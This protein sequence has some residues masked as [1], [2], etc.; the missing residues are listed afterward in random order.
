MLLNCELEV[1]LLFCQQT[2][3]FR[4]PLNN[5]LF[6]NQHQIYWLNWKVFLNYNLCHS[7]RIK[8]VFLKNII[9]VFFLHIFSSIH[10][11]RITYTLHH[12]R[13]D[14]HEVKY[15]RVPTSVWHNRLKLSILTFVRWKYNNLF[16]G[17]ICFYCLL[18]KF[19][20]QMFVFIILTLLKLFK[21]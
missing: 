15:A 20:F 2:Y 4:Y 5:K 13:F 8:N 1:I 17:V 10:S 3:I 16:S 19:V 7:L 11:H 9:S 6:Q 14:S 18:L 12:I 21:F